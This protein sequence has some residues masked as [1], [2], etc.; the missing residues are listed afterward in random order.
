MEW[1]I[2][3]GTRIDQTVKQ[4]WLAKSLVTFLNELVLVFNDSTSER[5]KYQMSMKCSTWVNL[6]SIIAHLVII[7]LSELQITMGYCSFLLLF[8][9]GQPLRSQDALWDQKLANLNLT[10]EH[11]IHVLLNI[12]FQNQGEIMGT[13]CCFYVFH[14]SEDAFY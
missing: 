13:L 12:L 8:K 6:C 3:N 14:S 5:V 10:L 4:A 1:F 9:T 11:H 2:I 7:P